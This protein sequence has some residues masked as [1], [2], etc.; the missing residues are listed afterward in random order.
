MKNGEKMNA[1]IN[2]ETEMGTT[3]TYILYLLYEFTH[4]TMPRPVRQVV[5][6]AIEFDT[7]AE[8][9]CFDS[10]ELMWAEKDVQEY[11]KNERLPHDLKD[12]QIVGADPIEG[13][14]K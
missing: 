12:L 14:I 3:K 9:K 7:E 4:D 8:C 2:R 10:L 6:Y 13:I 5:K 11:I 1:L